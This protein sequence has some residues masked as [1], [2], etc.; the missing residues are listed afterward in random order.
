MYSEQAI[1]KPSLKQMCQ[2]VE[3]YNSQVVMVP[4]YCT[5]LSSCKPQCDGR[6]NVSQCMNVKVKHLSRFR[7]L[8]VERV[9]TQD[10]HLN[11]L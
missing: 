10:K 3:N 8:V 11:S 6:S 5:S 7:D 1:D 9:K 4:Y 2:Q